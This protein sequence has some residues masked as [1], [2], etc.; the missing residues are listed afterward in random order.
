MEM[1]GPFLQKCE[2]TDFY[3]RFYLKIVVYTFFVFYNKD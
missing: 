3:L 1:F 2:V